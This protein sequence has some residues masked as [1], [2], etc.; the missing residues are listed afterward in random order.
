MQDN[1][2]I[3][4]KYCL[5]FLF[6]RD[7]SVSYECPCKLFLPVLTFLL[8]YGKLEIVE[9]GSVYMVDLEENARALQSIK[10]KLTSIGDSL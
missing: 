2:F 10:T 8:S 3:I 5:V 9:R 6:K 4:H 7:G 1:K